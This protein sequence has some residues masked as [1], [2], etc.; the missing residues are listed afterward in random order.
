MNL[1]N[2][3]AVPAV[4]CAMALSAFAADA[5]VTLSD[6]H[7]CCASCVKGV[8]AALTP[9]TGAKAV[10]DR[11]A[12][13]VVITAPDKETAQKAVDALVMAG[14]FGKSSDSSIKVEDVTGA[15]GSKVQ[16]LTVSGVHL[17]CPKC[18]TAVKA[19]LTKVDGVQGNTVVQKATSFTVTGDFNDK[20]V[21]DQLNQ[22]GLSGKVMAA[23][24]AK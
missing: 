7:L 23:P 14:Y 10:C 12:S 21:F 15:S 8:D 4:V 9:V 2:F 6:V 3:F 17:C 1:K 19:I 18:V 24:A 22:G 5:T 13:T 20:S 11:D 16:T